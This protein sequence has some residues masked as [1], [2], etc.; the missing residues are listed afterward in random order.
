MRSSKFPN[1][2]PRMPPKTIAQALEEIFGEYQIIPRHAKKAKT[3]KTKV[4][5]VAKENAAPEFR[6]NESFTNEPNTLIGELFS[7]C[8]TANALDV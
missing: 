3:V 6:A 2:P 1:A 5:P 7:N 4:A 8:M